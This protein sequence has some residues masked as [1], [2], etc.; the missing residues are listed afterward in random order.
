MFRIAKRTYIE[1]MHSLKKL[2][3]S[4]S[5]LEDNH[6]ERKSI[7]WV[8]GFLGTMFWV[9]NDLIDFSFSQVKLT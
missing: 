9:K 2:S 8:P 1:N 5:V 4:L 7:L 6:G 3:G